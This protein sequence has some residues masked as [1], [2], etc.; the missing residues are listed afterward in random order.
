MSLNKNFVDKNMKKRV[1]D[2]NGGSEKF[3]VSV[4]L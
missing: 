1:E 4:M 3:L 2:K